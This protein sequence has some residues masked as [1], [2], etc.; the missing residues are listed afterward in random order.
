MANNDVGN[1][2]EL[3][4]IIE[5]NEFIKYHKRRI[6]ILKKIL[7]ETND[8]RLILQISIL[9]LE[10]LA[11]LRYPNDNSKSRFIKLLSYEISK[12]DAR[13]FYEFYRC[14]LVHGGFLSPF[15]MSE[16][17]E[18]EDIAF[19]CLHEKYIDVGTDIFSNTNYP[20][21]T[22]IIIYEEL[23]Y[24]LEDYFKKRGTKSR[25]L[26]YKK[27]LRDPRLNPPQNPNPMPTNNFNKTKI[28]QQ[29]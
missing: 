12:K 4:I 20:P 18:D 19:G 7:Q 27:I 26:R 14:P 21:K 28:P 15:D 25:F 3:K 13:E 17:W 9:G 23:L 24:Y 2:E 6:K 10:S 5:I 8:R 16:A 11:R 29:K 1:K 22:L